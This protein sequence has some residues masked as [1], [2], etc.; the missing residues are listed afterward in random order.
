MFILSVDGVGGNPL[1]QPRCDGAKPCNCSYSKPYNSSLPIP[2]FVS[3]NNCTWYH[4][5]N[6]TLQYMT[7]TSEI[8]LPG[9]SDPNSFGIFTAN[10]SNNSCHYVVVP[11]KG[12]LHAVTNNYSCM[13]KYVRM[14]Y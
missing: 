8:T 7:N 13:Y 12:I 4:K 3:P 6:D 1:T 11:S 5:I 2:C 9:N 10:T 14:H